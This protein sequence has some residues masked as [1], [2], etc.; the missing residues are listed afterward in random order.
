MFVASS[1][2]LKLKSGKVSF[3]DTCETGFFYDGLNVEG[4]CQNKSCIVFNQTLSH[5]Y[6]YNSEF[7]FSQYD[8]CICVQCK[9]KISPITSI[10][11]IKSFVELKDSLCHQ[12]IL[13]TEYDDESYGELTSDILIE[14]C[15]IQKWD[16]NSLVIT[17]TKLTSVEEREQPIINDV[18]SIV[19]N[20]KPSIDV[21]NIEKIGDNK[22]NA[23]RAK[24]EKLEANISKT[25]DQLSDLKKKSQSISKSINA[26][27]KI[28][29]ISSMKENVKN[30]QNNINKQVLTNEQLV[31][32]IIKTDEETKQQLKDIEKNQELVSEKVVETTNILSKLKN[33]FVNAVSKFYQKICG[34]ATVLS[35]LLTGAS[36]QKHLSPKLQKKFDEQLD[37]LNEELNDLLKSQMKNNSRITSVKKIIETLKNHHTTVLQQAQLVHE[38]SKQLVQ[39]NDAI[40]DKVIDLA[41]S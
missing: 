26:C 29:D 2:D 12:K 16:L 17:C 13:E 25:G 32:E 24:V 20:R 19:N 6:R 8:D 36:D 7:L 41:C 18:D 33:L 31:D 15:K 10:T 37:T 28:D 21:K 9:L 5:T 14:F 35:K 22:V 40:D 23:V 4:I 38:L 3:V 39:L 11:A 30:L 34:V 27:V 1:G